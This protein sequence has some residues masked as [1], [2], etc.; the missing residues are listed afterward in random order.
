MMTAQLAARHQSSSGG[1]GSSSSRGG[2]EN[3][4]GGGGGGASGYSGANGGDSRRISDA[5]S[6]FGS[7]LLFG[8]GRR[9]GASEL[10]P[11]SARLERQRELARNIDPPSEAAL[12]VLRQ[13]QASLLRMDVVGLTED[14]HGFERALAARWPDMFGRGHGHTATPCAIP[15][16]SEAR[17]PTSR[18]ET[19]GNASTVLDDVTRAAIRSLNLMDTRLYDLAKEIAKSQAACVARAT[20]AG[21][22]RVQIGRTTRKCFADVRSRM[23]TGRTMGPPGRPELSTKA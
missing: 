3:S 5:L 8:G 21:M 2:S 11:L 6:G 17:N 4:R 22:D 18:H 19:R 23:S 16:G 10:T 20:A 13:A 7:D 12:S 9:L 15:S 1:S 14:M